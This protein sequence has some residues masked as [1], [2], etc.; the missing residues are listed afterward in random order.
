LGVRFK[1]DAVTV[2]IESEGAAGYLR[3]LEKSQVS[4]RTAGGVLY[5]YD[6]GIQIRRF[7]IDLEG[8]SAAEKAALHSFFDTTVNGMEEDFEYTDENGDTWSARFLSPE[9]VWEKHGEELWMVKFDLE[10]W[11]S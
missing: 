6:K 7:S 4:G 10:I 8:L 2:D 11:S 1:K 9:L 3:R 5:V